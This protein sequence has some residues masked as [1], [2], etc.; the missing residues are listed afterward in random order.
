MKSK[1]SIALMVVIVI[2][3]I[4]CGSNNQVA[5][6]APPPQQPNPYNYNGNGAGG[7]PRRAQGIPLRQ[8][9]YFADLIAGGAVNTLMVDLFSM[10]GSIDAYTYNIVGSGSFNFPDMMAISQYPVTSN[11]SFCVDSTAGNGV[12]TPGVL[13]PGELSI[14][15]VLRSTVQAPYSQPYSQ[16]Y[17][18][19]YTQPYPYPYNGGGYSPYP[20]YPPTG[21]M[22]QQMIELIIGGSYN[23]PAYL[24]EGRIVGCVDVNIGP[25]FDGS[26]TSIRYMA[27]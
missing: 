11:Y 18:Q 24:E 25:S 5:Q 8:G 13:V 21:Y 12:P 7:C 15:L 16:P 10:N 4:R 27:Q 2:G 14:S 9:P 22:G 23:C 26:I 20:S 3:L 6:P 1:V 19:P 17:T